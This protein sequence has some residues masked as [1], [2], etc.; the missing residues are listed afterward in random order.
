MVALYVWDV[1]AVLAE[2]DALTRCSGQIEFYN[3]L[4]S[5]LRR[6]HKST[7][8]ME[9]SSSNRIGTSCGL[10]KLCRLLPNWSS[11]SCIV[12]YYYN[13]ILDAIMDRARIDDVDPTLRS[14]GR[15]EDA[16]ITHQLLFL[17]RP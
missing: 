4:H 17:S 9:V 13:S 7:L 12:L 10:R 14:R 1:R 16:H 6:A 3:S 5:T 11:G 2:T 15:N 8:I